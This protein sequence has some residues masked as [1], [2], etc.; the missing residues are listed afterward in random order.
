MESVL[1]SDGSSYHQGLTF[2]FLLIG[3]CVWSFSKDIS[4]GLLHIA[5][6]SGSQLGPKSFFSFFINH[7][8]KNNNTS[9]DTDMKGVGA[10]IKGTYD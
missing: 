6:I 4:Q 9:A 3:H 1:C 7:L 8:K 2:T 10:N 5:S